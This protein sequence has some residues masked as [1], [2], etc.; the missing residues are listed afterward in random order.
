[1]VV[2]NTLIAILI[3]LLTKHLDPRASKINTVFGRIVSSIILA[4]FGIVIPRWMVLYINSFSTNKLHK[5][6]LLYYSKVSTVHCS[7][8]ELKFRC[9]WSILSYS[10]L[11]YPIQIT[12][13]MNVDPMTIPVSTIISIVFGFLVLM[14]VWLAI[15]SIVQSTWNTTLTMKKWKPRLE[16]R[17]KPRAV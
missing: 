6:S 17:L 15:V 3:S 8:K 2:I 5:Y 1:M 7:L 4:L 12:Y 9:C 13:F 10:F 16:P 14:D 11:I